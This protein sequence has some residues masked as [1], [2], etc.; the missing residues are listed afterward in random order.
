MSSGVYGVALRF[1]PEDARWLL[2]LA[3]AVNVG[4]DAAFRVGWHGT[5]PHVTLL[6][7]SGPELRAR[8]WLDMVRLQPV[9]GEVPLVAGALEIRAIGPGNRYVP[10]GGTYVGLEVAGYGGH[11]LPLRLHHV[12]IRECALD[13]GMRPVGYIR[14]Y[15]PHVTL[16]V[17]QPG[18]VRVE[19]LPDRRTLAGIPVF[20]EV[21][22]F[23]S[24]T[25]VE[26][27]WT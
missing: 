4:R 9:I 24:F 18:P 25:N 8:E 10:E 7:A 11:L 6:H 12:L 1:E 22:S 5:I 16:G 14:D 17:F 3:N 20:G 19:V 27:V 21:G 13:R 15:A 23:G 26:P 2:A